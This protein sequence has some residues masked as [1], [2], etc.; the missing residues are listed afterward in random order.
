LDAAKLSAVAK[1]RLGRRSGKLAMFSPS[2][3][4][5]HVAPEKESACRL[6]YLSVFA[7]QTSKE[8]PRIPRQGY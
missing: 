3:R 5:S 1:R 6:A 7:V 8:S 2:T 4:S